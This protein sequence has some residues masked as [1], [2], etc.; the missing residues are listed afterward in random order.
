MK[1]FPVYFDIILLVIFL[2][3]LF[4]NDLLSEESLEKGEIGHRPYEI[5]EAGRVKDSYPTL[6]DFETEGDWIAESNDSIATIM[7]SQEKQ[8]W[9]DWTAKLTYRART[10]SDKKENIVRIRPV[11]SII[12]PPSFDTICIWIHG[13]HWGSGANTDPNTPSPFLYIHFLL[14]DGKPYSFPLIRIN[15]CD[16]YLVHKRLTP[17]QITILNRPNVRLDGFSLCGG[18][19]KEDRILYLDDIGLFTEEF[20]PLSFS[21]RAKRGIDMFP[22]QDCGQNTGEARLPFPTRPETILPDSS[23]PGAKNHVRVLDEKK[24]IF[25]FLYEGKDGKLSLVF[26]PQNDVWTSWQASWNGS[27]RFCPIMIGGVRT[28][29]GRQGVTEPILRTELLDSKL[30][31]NQLVTRAKI[32]SKTGEAEVEY[33]FQLLGKSLQIDTFGKKGTIHE[34]NFGKMEG[35]SNARAI[36]IPYY[37]SG[38]G[39]ARPAV[40]AFELNKDNYEPNKD[41]FEPH[42]DNGKSVSK[43]KLFLFGCIDWYRSNASTVFA[44]N[45]T[46]DFK[47]IYHGG[48]RY[49]PKTDK[50]CNPVFER[51]FVTISPKMEEVFPVIPNPRS[52]WKHI[53]GTKLWRVHAANNREE[54]KKIWNYVHRHGIR[55]VIINDHETGWRDGGD[56][57]TFRTRTAPGKG[58]DRG[59]EEY[60]RYIKDTLGYW[61]GPYNNFTDFAPVNQYWSF[62]MIGRTSDNRLHPAWMR[63][64]GPKPAR[65]VEY[66][67]K[68]TPIIQKKFNFNTAYCDVHTSVLP[69]DRTDY[70]SRVPGAAT[71]AAVFYAYGEIMMIQK[72]DWNGPVYSEGPNHF[73]YS[74][75]TDGNYAQDRGYD[76]LNQPWFVDFDLRQMHDLNCNFGMGNLAM[77]SPSKTTLERLYYLPSQEEPGDT[78]RSRLL[79]RFLAAT[80]AFGHPGFLVLDY[81]F[82]PP[83]AFGLAYGLPG[84]LHLDR[85]IDI[86]MLSYYMIQQIAARYTQSTVE[87]IYWI[88]SSGKQ[89]TISEAIFNDTFQRNQLFVQYQDGTNVVVNGNG[90]ENMKFTSNAKTFELPPYGYRAWTK[91]GSVLVESACQNGTRYD[92]CESPDYIYINGRGHWHYLSRAAGKGSAVCLFGQEGCCEIISLNN[93]EVGFALDFEKAVALDFSGKEIGVAAVVKREGYSFIQ[94]VEG[95]FSY[96]VQIKYNDGHN[97][98]NKLYSTTK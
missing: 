81:C 93:E 50:T 27:K 75:L 31:G 66:C 17:E 54:D 61:Y 76:F 60:T 88:D 69:W 42:K 85:G 8:I 9:G 7:R 2:T 28:I 14:E 92:Y 41:K 47:A 21:T 20:K 87:N 22:G 25:E 97:I 84:K 68:L 24:K 4:S 64:Y 45:Y 71:F 80:L 95:A 79:D 1:K 52:P 56:S 36:T 26:T 63:C 18:S 33:R 72:K 44:R 86:A 98:K 94:S 39:K 74:G 83:K 53:T 82:D 35:V 58:G 23:V 59:Q 3:W 5:V 91:D 37:T 38:T 43:E 29:A 15:W 32:T 49:F 96:R 77:F 30:D 40:I 46:E 16:W 6:V 55:E 70:D 51:F 48:V 13:N 73:Y 65:A 78:G 89:F 10:D 67:E 57:F 90:M 12:V 62:D 34:I 11:D 19:N